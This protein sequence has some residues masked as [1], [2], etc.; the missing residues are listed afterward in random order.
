MPESSPLATKAIDPA[1]A[2][3]RT[4]ATP[5]KPSQASEVHASRRAR[6][7]SCSHSDTA[8]RREPGRGCPM[9]TRCA[10]RVTKRR[11]AVLVFPLNDP[12]WA[13]L[14]IGTRKAPGARW[15]PALL[16]LLELELP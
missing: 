6:R 1:S 9:R 15:P 12:G 4:V 8:T 5:S 13:K 2:P 11:I 16:E 7:A 14:L 10:R 3:T